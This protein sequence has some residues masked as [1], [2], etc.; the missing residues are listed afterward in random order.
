MIK[1]TE[2]QK[3]HIKTLEWYLNDKKRQE[4]K[5]FLLAYAAIKWM[6]KNP[7]TRYKWIDFNHYPT[8]QRDSITRHQIENLW[9]SQFKKKYKQF[10]L[11]YNHVDMTYNLRLVG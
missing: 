8:Y 11:I 9:N 10:E 2:I 3:K 6:I 7:Q 1:L 4:G 5:T